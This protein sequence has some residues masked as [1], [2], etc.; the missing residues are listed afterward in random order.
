MFTC[1]N[2]SPGKRIGRFGTANGDRSF[3]RDKFLLFTF[4][5]V[6]AFLPLDVITG[7]VQAFFDR[8]GKHESYREQ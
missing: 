2:R 8:A 1:R 6:Q 3:F 5:S 7:T 4:R